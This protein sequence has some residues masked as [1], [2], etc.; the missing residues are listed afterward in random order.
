M[1]HV[2]LASTLLSIGI[3]ITFAAT[4]QKGI[5]RSAYGTAGFPLASPAAP[6]SGESISGNNI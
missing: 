4:G 6:Q 1:V 3:G 2:D 5:N